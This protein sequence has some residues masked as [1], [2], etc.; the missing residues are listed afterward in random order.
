M[1]IS[2]KSKWIEELFWVLPLAWMVMITPLF[3]NWDL[4]VANWFYNAETKSFS[5]P[6]IAQFLYSFGELPAQITGIVS[7]ILWVISYFWER[8]KSWKTVLLYLV[9]T[10]VLGPVLIVNGVLKDNWGRP[11]PKQTHEFGGQMEYRPYYS[12][13]FE[14]RGADLKSLPSGHASCGYYF[15]VLY[16]L[17]RR[18]NRKYL[19]YGGLAFAIVLGIILS[20]TRLSQGGHF[21]S[22]TIISALLMWLVAYFCDRFIFGPYHAKT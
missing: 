7:F 10:M 1:N 2:L 12:P 19:Q 6:P 21:L 15:F 22:D 20:I 14:Y 5:N 3:S 4:Q 17:G 9:A 13:S 16:F 18:F 8:I 11:R